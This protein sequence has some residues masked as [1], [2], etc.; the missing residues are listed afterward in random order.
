MDAFRNLTDQKQKASLKC[1]YS[2]TFKHVK[3]G[4]EKYKY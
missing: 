2:Q 4:S 1:V 3:A